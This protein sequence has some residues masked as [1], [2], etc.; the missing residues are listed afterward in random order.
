MKVYADKHEE[1]KKRHDEIWP[2][3][4]QAIKE[5][6]CKS[7]SIWLDEENNLLFAYLEIEDED[8]WS[9]L[10]KTAINQKWWTYMKDVMETNEDDSPVTLSLNN[11]FNI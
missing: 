4:E 9:Q 1:Y 2:E 10:S 5:H 11:V 3:L 8:R 6:G 7:Y